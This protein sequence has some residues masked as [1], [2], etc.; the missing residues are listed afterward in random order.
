MIIE[1]SKS[2][3]LTEGYTETHHII[4]KSLGGLNQPSNLSVL[5]GREH[6]LCH[7]LLTKMI[8]GPYVHKMNKALLI[9][10]S[11]NKISSRLYEKL[12]E[13]TRGVPMSQESKQ[14][15][16]QT[17]KLKNHTPWNK[18]VPRTEQEKKS[19]SKACLEARLTKPVWNKGKKHSLETLERIRE[20]AV[21][22]TNITCKHCNMSC[23]PSNHKRWHGD[24]CK[25]LFR[26]L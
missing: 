11:R 22:R 7:W 13:N 15:L 20:K 14:K 5:T 3:T 9:M 18:G 1:R 8:K 21:R 16:S 25:S 4:P 2:R 10:S 24:N 19:I 17:K 26:N 12:G 23:S 6:F